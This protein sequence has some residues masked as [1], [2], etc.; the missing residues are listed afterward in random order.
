MLQCTKKDLR[1]KIRVTNDNV[2]VHMR[3]AFIFHISCRLSFLRIL[4]IFLESQEFSKNCGSWAKT[5]QNIRISSNFI[6]VHLVFSNEKYRYSEWFYGIL[7]QSNLFDHSHSSFLS[8]ISFSGK[9]ESTRWTIHKWTPTSTAYSS[10]NH[11]NGHQW[12]EVCL[13]S[14]LLFSRFMVISRMRL[15]IK[16]LYLQVL[17]TIIIDYIMKSLTIVLMSFQ[18]YFK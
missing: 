4:R 15:H 18:I 13:L 9:S 1:L 3:N 2:D 5:L 12:S 6:F 7:S 8:F 10:Q 14:F 16:A 11:R 17:M